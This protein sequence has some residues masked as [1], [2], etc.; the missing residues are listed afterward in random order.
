VIYYLALLVI[1]AWLALTPLVPFL[2]FRA[3]WE[4]W[5]KRDSSDLWGIFAAW[6]F[7]GIP[8]VAGLVVRFGS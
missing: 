1:I 3:V 6:A 8:I 5:H 4:T 2:I 7:F